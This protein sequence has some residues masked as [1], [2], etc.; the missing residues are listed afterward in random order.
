MLFFQET[1]DS[2]FFVNHPYNITK[3]TFEN[4]SLGLMPYRRYEIIN[5]EDYYLDKNILLKMPQIN[6]DVGIGGHNLSLVIGQDKVLSHDLFDFTY[7]YEKGVFPLYLDHFAQIYN[8][9][10]DNK[11][12]SVSFYYKYLS[13][14]YREKIKPTQKYYTQ[15]I[16]INR[17]IFGLSNG[18]LYNII[19]YE[20]KDHLTTMIKQEASSTNNT[21]FYYDNNKSSNIQIQSIE[22]IFACV[23]TKSNTSYIVAF[24]KSNNKTYLFSIQI[25]QENFGISYIP[26][27]ILKKSIKIEGNPSSFQVFNG[28]LYYIMNG[29]VYKEGT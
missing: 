19:D 18:K 26:I 21:F 1:C 5:T 11:N 14:H 25:K 7:Y 2:A 15:V 29:E 27:L 9:S 20:K 8:N 23:D 6:S 17:F 4:V 16:H 13:P 24:D 28:S 3:L 22:S 12:V 10:K